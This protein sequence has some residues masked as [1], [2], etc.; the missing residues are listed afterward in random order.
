MTGETAPPELD[1]DFVRSQFPAFR[2]PS[3]QGMGTLRERR[4]L[5]CLSAGDRAPRLVLSPDEG[6]ALLPVPGLSERRVTRWTK[7]TC[8]SR[9]IST[10]AKTRSIS[11][12]RL[13]RTRTCWRARSGSRAVRATRSSSRTRTTR[14]TP[15][16][17]RRL[18]ACGM[19]VKEWC[20]D[21]D[22]GELDPEALED[23]VGPRTRLVA[24][25]HCSNVVAHVNPVRAIVDQV[26]SR[27]PEAIVLVDGV[28][29]APHG[30]P[31][32]RALG[33]DIYLFSLY[34]TWGPHLGVMT[35][36][37]DLVERL[38]NQGHFF[39]ADQAR[40][41]LVPAATRSCAD[42]GCGRCSSVLRRRVDSPFRDRDG[43]RARSRGE[44]RA[45]SSAA[46]CVCSSRDA[47]ARGAA[48]LAA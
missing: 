48:R 33:A 15:G 35:L 23:L 4:W 26:K 38:A 27:A 10:W 11:G 31:D 24:F 34:K 20:I 6:P 42:C 14:P 16:F 37:R 40:K 30:W 13:P 1:V 28:S 45:R 5:V 29:A 18:A 46:R 39:N 7:P 17:W 36:R 44:C 9:A 8:A 32:V 22:S 43:R 3:L 19:T 21:P 2:E 41:R 47:T 12:R 25:P